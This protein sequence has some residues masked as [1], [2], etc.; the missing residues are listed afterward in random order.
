MISK[1]K[2]RYL[3]ALYMPEGFFYRGDVLCYKH[4]NAI[5]VNMVPTS[6]PE[7]E[8]FKSESVSVNIAWKLDRILESSRYRNIDI[9]PNV[10]PASIQQF[11]HDWTDVVFPP[12][13]I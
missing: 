13:G 11:V 1:G 2:R 8:S 3:V 6:S 10:E 4:E 5:L 12:K 9:K 7:V